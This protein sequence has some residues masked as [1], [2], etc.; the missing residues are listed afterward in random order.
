MNNSERNDYFD[1][2]E[3]ENPINYPQLIGKYL[4]YWPWF[5]V[6]VVAAFFITTVYLRYTDV[7]YSTEANVK[8]IDDKKNSNFSL[9]MSRMFSKSSINLENEIALFK[10]VRLA[11]EVV[12]NLKLN[13]SYAKTGKVKARAVFNPPFVVTYALPQESL[14]GSYTFTITVTKSGYKIVDEK[15]GKTINTKGFWMNAP[16]A[17]FPITIHPSSRKNIATFLNESY[18]VSINP[19]SVSALGLSK[20]IDVEPVGKE[21]DIIA[22]TLKGTDGKQSEDILNN[23]IKVFGEDGVKDNQQVSRRTINFVDERFVYLKEE[24]D[25]IE[26]S[27]KE[28]KK[29]NNISFIQGDAGATVLTK[30]AKE[31]ALFDVE[32]QLLLAQLLQDNLKGQTDF[33]LLPAN[34]GIQSETINKLVEGYNLSVLQFQKLQTSAG[35]NNPAI[36][37]LRTQIA[38]EKNNILN[39]VKGYKQQLQVSRTQGMI[40]ERNAQGSFSALPEKEK[41]L[42]SIERQ[43]DLKESLYLLLLQKREEASINLAV[44]VPNTK[45][46][47]YAITNSAPISPK[48]N[49]FYLA[50]LLIGL[51]I[52]FGIL[53]IIFKLDN[54]VHSA[55]DIEGKTKLPIL[56]ELPALLATPESK[57]QSTEGF[58]TLVHSTDFITPYTENQEG[59]V[60]FVTSSIKGEGKT[61]V[62]YNLAGV[63]ADFNKKTILVGADF[64]NPQLHKYIHQSRKSNKGFSNYLHD[65]AVQWEDLVYKTKDN[66]YDF[67]IL[68]SGEIPPNPSLLLSNPRFAKI[69]AELKKVY[70]I[71]II[72][73]P[74]TL[75]VS[76]SLIISKYADTTL[77]VVRSGFTAKNLISHSS[78]LSIDKKIINMGYVINDIDFSRSYGYGY[79]YN[80]GYGYGYIQDLD[81]KPWYKRLF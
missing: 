25:S 40:A 37:L 20:S 57:M 26:T 72:D 59:K 17:N 9:D 4:R 41:V 18:I 60:I 32:S 14:L 68:L 66:E 10:S 79:G 69:I 78:K 49:V 24:L 75:L 42:R 64:R 21:S 6:T 5:I 29:T 71:I 81:K 1:F 56:A 19:I 65:P 77:Y 13:I 23:L 33:S 73:T 50:A 58:R 31:Q 15:L 38:E 67:D 63:Y 48:K 54:K 22:L 2:I 39:S 7:I 28:Y 30:T 52:P 36:Q 45:I 46:I 44:T 27:K 74:P 12:T 62:S 16:V 8:I 34:I 51:G 3:D 43:Q 76:D 70:D 80:Y 47:D 53:F 35:V 55:K 11:E 61:F